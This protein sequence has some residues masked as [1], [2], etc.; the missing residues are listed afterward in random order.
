MFLDDTDMFN[1]IHVDDLWIYDKL[2]LSKKLGYICG[3]HGA[4]VPRFGKYIV[5]PCVNFMG[6]GRGAHFTFFWKSSENKMPEGSFWCEVFKGRHLSVDY[7]NQKQHL[8]VEGIK[9]KNETNLW[10]W[11]KWIKTE[12]KIPLPSILK[13]LRKKYKYINCEFID[14][15]LIEIH[16]RLNVD[17]QLLPHAQEIVPLFKGDIVVPPLED[18]EFIK[19]KDYKRLGF[20]WK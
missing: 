12:D 2:I 20:Y 14:G 9:N 3:P 13:S 1:K 11:L 7:I 5:R 4:D 17:W 8:C 6:M 18:Y 10:R 19:S 16:L 15:K